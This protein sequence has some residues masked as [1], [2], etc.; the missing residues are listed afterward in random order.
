MVHTS[1]TPVQHTDENV[2]TYIKYY[3]KRFHTYSE[4]KVGFFCFN[5]VL[6]YQRKNICYSAK[7][8]NKF[9]IQGKPGVVIIEGTDISRL[10]GVLCRRE[11]LL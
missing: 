7:E 5:S 4:A 11:S 10:N 6:Q 9:L 2:S 1:V 8:L 3:I